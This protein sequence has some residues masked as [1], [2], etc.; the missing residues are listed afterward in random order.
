MID[1]ECVCEG[2]ARLLGPGQDWDVSPNGGWLCRPCSESGVVIDLSA[3]PPSIDY[4]SDP[5]IGVPESRRG[6]RWS[7]PTHRRPHTATHRC[8]VFRPT[9]E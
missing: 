7:P 8:V 6:P 1:P 4:L 2:C 9:S 5:S 3:D